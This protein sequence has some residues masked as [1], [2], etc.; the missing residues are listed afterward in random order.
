MR[1]LLQHILSMLRPGLL[2]VALVLLCSNKPPLV[3]D[4]D[5]A[6]ESTVKA[7]FLYNFTKHIEW[8]ASV[9][10]SS[11]FLIGTYGENDVKDKLNTVMKGRRIFDKP[12]EIRQVTGI[13]DIAGL[14]ILYIGKSQSASID[15][16]VQQ[17]GDKG[18]LIITEEKSSGAKGSGINL[19]RKGENLRFEINEPALKKAGLK[20]SNQLIG[21]AISS[22]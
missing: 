16:I 12:V 9:M 1:Y 11:R 4:N 2:L 13:D 5:S 17:F 8:P 7:L 14:H 19:L 20:V 18:I 22:R 21:L 6:S 15:K 10:N 3:Q